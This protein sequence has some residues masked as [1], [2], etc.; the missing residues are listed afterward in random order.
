MTIIG[1]GAIANAD[2][3]SKISPAAQDVL[4][5]MSDFLAAHKEFSF[6][7]EVSTDDAVVGTHRIHTTDV[8][9][10]VVRRPNKL[11]INTHGDL[12][13]KRLWYDGSTVALLSLMD[14]FYATAKCRHELTKLSTSCGTSTKLPRR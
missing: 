5:R 9:E 4:K 11:W 10:A 2:E 1:S 12:F 6:E 14:N 8:I 7:A 13:N 3:P